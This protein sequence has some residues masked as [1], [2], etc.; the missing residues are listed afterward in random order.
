MIRIAFGLALSALA[1]PAAAQVAPSAGEAAAYAGLFRAA[2]DGDLAGLGAAIA[3]G[4]PLE[5]RDGHG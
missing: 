1:L 2:H 3:S 4:A 5:A